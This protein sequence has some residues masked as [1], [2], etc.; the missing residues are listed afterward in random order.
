MERPV[1]SV[2]LITYNQRAFIAQA[3]ESILL[4]NTSFPIEIVAGDDCS[5][6]GTGVILDGYKM[7]YPEKFRM[8]PATRR[9]GVVGNFVRTLSCCAGKYVALLEG[10]D[11]WTSPRKLQKQV[12]LLEAH[13]ETSICFHDA[14]VMRE[15]GGGPV[16]FAPQHQK[17][18]S[19]LEDL[20]HG[21]FIPTA[22]AV[23][24]HD[25]NQSYPRE[26]E[27][28]PMV[29]WPLHALHARRGDVRFIEEVMSVYRLHSGSVWSSRGWRYQ[30]EN[31]FRAL[32]VLNHY[33]KGGS[34]AA[35][36]RGKEKILAERLK[37]ATGLMN[38]RAFAEAIDMLR[39]VLAFRPTLLDV[40]LALAFALL[41]IDRPRESATELEEILR[42]DPGH[43]G[44]QALLDKIYCPV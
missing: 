25:P 3:V 30:T 40:R 4:Q 20:L 24:R 33:F 16:R 28:L 19:T 31:I 15:G 34:L 12:D 1:L 7:Q 43:A 38:A 44:A 18:V 36:A 41:Q 26:L 37:E 8:L 29:D 42:R 23:Y 14:L 17:E 2:C 11:Y 5:T 13:P 10:D 32:D 27:C 35:A 9:R 21:N 22:S 39:D 6:D